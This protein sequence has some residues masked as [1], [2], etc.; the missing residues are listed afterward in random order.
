MDI[1][2]LYSAVIT[3]L[4]NDWNLTTDIDYPNVTT[5][6]STPYIRPVFLP[7]GNERAEIGVNGSDK[8][9]VILSI[10]IFTKVGAG[11]G[12][13]AELMGSVMDMFYAGFEITS[14]KGK[15]ITFK[16]PVPL[17]G[18]DG[19]NGLWMTTVHCPW[20]CFKY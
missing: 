16:T 7:L 18:K 6:P 11:I 2:D 17:A 20:Y 13:S 1:L 19:E 10:D 14:D 3:K 4:R 12:E 8:L 9:D 5:K 15:T